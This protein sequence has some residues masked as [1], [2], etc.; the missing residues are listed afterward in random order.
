MSTGGRDLF[1]YLLYCYPTEGDPGQ[2]K[3]KKKTPKYNY[4]KNNTKK[5]K[6]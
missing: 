5:I 4:S 3:I 2:L 6:N 1:M